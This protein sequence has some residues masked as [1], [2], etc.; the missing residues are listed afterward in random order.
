MEKNIKWI[1]LELDFVTKMMNGKVVI[2]GGGEE[3]YVDIRTPK[4]HNLECV[5]LQGGSQW[6]F[7]PKTSDC[8]TYK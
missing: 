6:C 5:S 4:Q 7:G 8:Y 3:K 2:C 1:H